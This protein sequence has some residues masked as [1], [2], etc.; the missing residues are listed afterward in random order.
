MLQA[1]CLG[2]LGVGCA[3]LVWVVW[4]LCALQKHFE[5]YEGGEDATQ[6]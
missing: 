2:G 6:G 5:Q 4:G 3:V 1:L